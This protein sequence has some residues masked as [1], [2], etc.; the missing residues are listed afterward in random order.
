TETDIEECKCSWLTTKALELANEEQKKILRENYGIKDPAKVAKVKELYHVLDL[1]GAYEDYETN[2][3]EKSMTTI[4]VHPN[5]V[6][7]AVLKSYLEKMYKGHKTDFASW[8]QCIQVYCRGKENRVNNLKSIDEGPFQMGTFRETLAKGE[9]GAVYLGPERARVY[10][11]LSPTSRGNNAR[12]K[13]TAGYEGSQNRV[14]NANP[15]QA[16]QIKQDVAD[17]S[18][19]EWVTLDEE[20]LLFIVDNVVVGGQDNVVAGGQDTVVAGG[21]DNVVDDNVMRLPL[22]RPCS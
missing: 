5:I 17:A 12:G 15:G 6:V 7:Q 10:S 4:K 19:G 20:Q 16:R 1:K 21:Q 11:D 13:G 3:Y 18:S 2:L 8:Q 22:H 9:E 14:G